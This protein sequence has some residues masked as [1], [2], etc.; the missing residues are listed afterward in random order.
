TTQSKRLINEG[1]VDWRDFMKQTIEV[2]NE[3]RPP[4]PPYIQGAKRRECEDRRLYELTD[5]KEDPILLL[6]KFRDKHQGHHQQQQ[7]QDDVGAIMM[8]PCPALCSSSMDS[9]FMFIRAKAMRAHRALSKY[10]NDDD[11]SMN[12][13]VTVRV[14][15]KDG[16]V[17]VEDF[18]K[19]CTD[20]DMIMDG[21][22]ALDDRA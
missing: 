11:G 6:D 22:D 19:T 8:T 18:L 10:D 1:L 17:D 5:G 16:Y 14:S 9:L 13:E 21:P 20:D 15:D 2:E 7:Q 4:T 12:L 3:Y